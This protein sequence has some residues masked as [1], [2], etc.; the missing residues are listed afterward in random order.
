LNNQYYTIETVLKG[1]PDKICDQISDGILDVFLKEDIQTKAGIECL[2]VSNNLIV[3]G[4]IKSNADVDIIKIAKQVYKEIGYT[5]ELKIINNVNKQSNQLNKVV[6]KGCAGDQ[7]VMYGFA[8]NE[9]KYNYLPF[10]IL[11][12]NEIAR[13]IDEYRIISKSFLPD[14]KIQA[15]IKNNI[16]DTLIISLQHF[17]HTNLNDLEKNIKHI[18]FN[19]DFKESSV[20]NLIFDKSDFIKGGFSNDT[21]LTGRK[22]II[23]TYC[24]LSQHGG[25]A[26]SGK[27]P[28]KMDRSGSYMSRFVAKN[29]VANGIAK[30]CTVSVSYAFGIENPIM[31]TASTS[32]KFNPKLTKFINDKFDFRPNAIIELLNLTK[33]EYKPTSC[34]GHFTN[35]SYEWEKIITL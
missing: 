3:A 29:I 1:H 12:I 7:G 34:Y 16:I 17:S 28:S 6:E 27:D 31:L 5:N 13:K 25:G 32:D 20:K 35:R 30:E 9:D 19:K 2:G 10:G 11:L 26:F 15:T 33:I 23:D 21:G 24:G 22:I 18:I 4:E 8:S 14:G